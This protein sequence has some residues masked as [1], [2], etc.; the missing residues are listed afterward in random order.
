MS[1]LGERNPTLSERGSR[2]LI[3]AEVKDSIK[4]TKPDLYYSDRDKLEE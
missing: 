3:T 2:Q 4:I 1:T